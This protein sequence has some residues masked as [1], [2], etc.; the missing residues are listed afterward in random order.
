MIRQITL[1]T[2]GAIAVLA[3][4]ACRAERA[5]APAPTNPA[6]SQPAP[7]LQGDLPAPDHP[8]EETSYSWSQLLARDAIRPVYVPEFAPADQAPYEDD[9]LVIGVALNGEAKAYAIGP[10]NSREMVND[11]IGGVPILV[12]W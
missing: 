11:T 3:I 10:L 7:V 4:T 1:V 2:A 5:A 9:E 8:L 6:P 12:T